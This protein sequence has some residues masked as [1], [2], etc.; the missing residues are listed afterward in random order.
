MDRVTGDVGVVCR[1][2]EKM[3]TALH[4]AVYF[5]SGPGAWLKG[6]VPVAVSRLRV[7]ERNVSG[8]VPKAKG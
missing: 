8:L 2:D 4:V 6:E 3:P 7:L 5:K 1:S